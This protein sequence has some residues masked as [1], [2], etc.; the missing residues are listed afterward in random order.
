MSLLT[1]K[2]AFKVLWRRPIFTLISL[3]GI[4][5]TMVTLLVA[6]AMFEQALG[7]HYPE[8]DRDRM[9]SVDWMRMEGPN[10]SSTGN[11]GFAF[12]SK[13]VRTLSSAELVSIVTEQ[14]RGA[15]YAGE[16]K[17]MVYLKRT[18]G[19]F[20]QMIQ[21]K[22]LE[23]RAL[24]VEDDSSGRR[25]AVLN[26]ST[27]NQL[28]SGAACVGQ[29]IDLDGHGFQVVGVVEDVPFTSKFSFADVW[30]THGSS[31]NS[32][33]MEQ[34]SEGFSAMIRARRVEDL[35]KIKSELAARLPEIPLPDTKR[36]KKLLVV[37][38]T[39]I[40]AFSREVLDSDNGER[41]VGLVVT[42][43][44]A[45]VVLFMLLP[46]VNLANLNISRTLERTSEIGVR[47]AFGASSRAMVVQFLS[48]NLI[49]TLI[50]AAISAI[51]A[52]AVLSLINDTGWMP[53]SRL[54]INA[55]VLLC[56]LLLALLFGVL[57][58][59]YPA[60]RM[61]RLHPAEALRGRAA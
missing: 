18:D 47:R 10:G 11:P 16:T 51:V 58:G 52:Q 34:F 24:T 14:R 41:R 2:L 53:Y 5:V 8:L 22:I 39:P 35:P 38:E 20:W 21:V 50:G 3:F 30:V 19:A 46:A 49:L 32:E 25:M 29:S 37:A 31:P 6:A 33:Y 44:M 55:P 4:V 60:W 36:F 42:L 59:A 61:S 7:T 45:G 54:S 56:G 43:F 17:A 12:L 48:E 1:I 13:Y 57:S 26:R 23:G 27:C 28:F 40:E 9:L 15:V